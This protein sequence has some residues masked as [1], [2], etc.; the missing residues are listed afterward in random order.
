LCG[1]SKI[2]FI[3]QERSISITLFGFN[4]GYSGWTWNVFFFMDGYNGYNQVKI[5]K[6]NKDNTSFIFEWGT[7]AYNFMPFGLCNV[8]ITF[9]KVIIQTFKEYINDFMQIFKMI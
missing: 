8:L 7:Y 5:A 2:E 1:L 4:I 9:Q 3:N 6:E